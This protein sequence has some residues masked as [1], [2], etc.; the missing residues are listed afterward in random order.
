MTQ[1]RRAVQKKPTP[2][3]RCACPS[4]PVREPQAEG[5]RRTHPTPFF[6]YRTP[7]RPT[8]FT[9]HAASRNGTRDGTGVKRREKSSGLTAVH[10]TVRFPQFPGFFQCY[11][12]ITSARISFSVARLYGVRDGRSPWKFI[13]LRLGRGSWLFGSSLFFVSSPFDFP[14]C[15]WPCSSS[16]VAKPG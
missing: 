3:C 15:S 16:L 7:F 2:K 9:T 13:L 14:G 8:V 5:S 10:G 11:F 4:K 12:C 1:G 6:F